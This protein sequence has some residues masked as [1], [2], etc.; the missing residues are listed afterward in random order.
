M[1]LD[2]KKVQ[3]QK[4]KLEGL[5]EKLV[6]VEGSIKDLLWSGREQKTQTP[7]KDLVSSPTEKKEASPIQV[8]PS[9][10]TTRLSFSASSLGAE[11]G[12]II[13]RSQDIPLPASGAC[14][15]VYEPDSSGRLVEYYSKTTPIENAIG[16]WATVGTKKIA[17]FK[18]KSHGNVIIAACSGGSQGRKNYFS[19][20]CTFVRAACHMQSELIMW[21]PP[22]KGL[23]VD[24]WVYTSDTRPGKQSVKL[25]PGVPIQT[26]GVLGAA[27]L[28]KNT[29][30]YDQAMTI[31]F[32]KWLGEGF[33]LG[34]S[35]RI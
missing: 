24:V 10:T 1:E 11:Y 27:V 15:L 12:S 25:E 5:L 23:N 26:E 7:K 17:G 32:D 28:P 29:Q 20:W 18:F 35:V 8:P 16:R 33:D 21:D 34:G 13:P 6:D 4:E 31:D 14:Y 2:K 22:G 3:E 9:P 19:G 30:F